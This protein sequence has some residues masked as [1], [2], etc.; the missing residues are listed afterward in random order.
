M[1]IKTRTQSPEERLYHMMLLFGMGADDSNGKLIIDDKGHLTLEHSY[2]LDQIVLN[3]IVEAMKL[4]AN[5]IGKNG[6]NDLTVLLWSEKSKSQIS[7]HPLGGC[8][9]GNSSSDGVV[10]SFGE[11]FKIDSGSTYKDLHVVDGSIIPNALGVNPSL[12]ISALAFR[13]AERITGNKKYW[14]K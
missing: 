4:F 10:N 8:P 13:I 14:P 9:M 11:V 6:E 5:G 7:A 3:N 2:N 12:T 1:D